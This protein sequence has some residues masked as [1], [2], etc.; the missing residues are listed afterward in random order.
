MYVINDAHRHGVT[1]L[2]SASSS[3]I[4]SGG[5][6]GEVRIWKISK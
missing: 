2:I 1:A 4:I 6:E 5:V 3:R